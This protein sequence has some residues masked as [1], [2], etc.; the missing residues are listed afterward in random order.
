MSDGVVL[1]QTISLNG[2]SW[3]LAADPRNVGKKDGWFIAA[4]PEA[5]NAP[6]PG[7]IQQVLPGYSGYAWYWKS[8]A[9]QKNP[10]KAGTYLLRFWDLDYIGEV[11]VNGK[12]V[13]SHE[14]AQQRFDL[15]I[16]KAVK[17]GV[18]NLIAIK[19]LSPFGAPIDGIE[20]SQTPH[21]ALRDFNLGGLIDDVELLVRPS[22]YQDDLFVRPNWQTGQVEVE[23][24]TI[25]TTHGPLP[26]TFR[27]EISP[28]A[29]GEPIAQTSAKLYLTSGKNSAEARLRVPNHILWDLKKPYLYR[30]TCRLSIDG[31]TSVDQ[32]AT[33][34]GFRDFRFVDGFF[35]LNGKRIFWSSAHTGADTPITISVPVDSSMV[36]KDL[37]NLKLCGFTGIRFISMLGKRAQLDMADELGLLVYEESY[38]SWMLSDSP[39]LAERFDRSLTG[40]V[41]RDRNHP[42]VAM[43]GLLNETGPGPVCDHARNSLPLMRMLDPTRPVMFSSGRFDSETFLN[44][45]VVW[46]P[47]TGF[48]P[49]IAFNPKTYSISGV[50]LFRSHEAS[51]IPGVNGEFSCVRFVAPEDGEYTVTAKFRG[52]GT[53]TISDVYVLGAG[54]TIFSS[55]INRKGLGDLARFEGTVKLAKGETVDFAVGGNTPAGG[56]WYEKWGNNTSLDLE[57]S[58]VGRRFHLSAKSLVKQN[59]YGEWQFGWMT[60]GSTPDPAQFKLYGLPRSESNATNGSFSNPG[61]LVWENLLGDQ[62]YYPRV[63]HRELEIARLRT[64]AIDDKP[65]FL[66]EYGIGGGVDMARFIANCEMLGHGSDD[67]LAGLKAQYETFKN[68]FVRLKL[69]DE[70]ASPQDFLQKAVE[71]EGAMKALGLNALRSNPNLV[72]YGMTGLNDPLE[73]GEGFITAFRELK[74]GT[75][76]AIYEGLAPVK[77]C[78]FAE[79]VQVYSG[80]EVRL[81]AVLSNFDTLPPGSYSLR[82]QAVDP[83]GKKVL[84]ERVTMTVTP[85][86]ASFVTP[87]FDR[88]VRVD[89]PTGKYRF[90]VQFESGAAATGGEA[91][92]YVANRAEMPADKSDVVLWGSDPFLENGLS[93]SGIKYHPYTPDSSSNEVILVSAAAPSPNDDKVWQDL[94][95]RIKAGSTAVFLCP[96]V[97]AKGDQQLGWLPLDKKGYLSFVSEFTFPQVYPKDEWCKRHPIFE[98]LPTGLMDHTFY[99]EMIPDFQFAGLPTPDEAVAGAFRTSMPGAYLCNSFVS[100]YKLGKG[101][102]VL[103]ALR[104]RQELGNDPVAER[105]LRNMLRYAGS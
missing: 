51:A 95:D 85:K 16:T 43:W 48:A 40:M 24:V 47:D 92:F 80:S 27:V 100:V 90:I 104:I 30:V 96:E 25:N 76:D 49:A 88:F 31:S 68:D 14:G 62:H 37:L 53:F 4:R 98:G 66:S 17:P 1:N 73:C 63:P 70:F 33:R 64:I 44:G 6:V 5:K 83:N 11:W 103:N 93:K 55:S 34:F 41:L 78:A 71:R 29:G 79:P 82:V 54:K 32:V 99:R 10:H 77:L 12:P 59:P 36:R 57:V 56:A 15:D 89:G 105:L 61:S 7:T 69:E 38:A 72:G 3:Q 94:V 21:G 22:V 28:A 86:S 58:G 2:N 84:N 26:A 23:V 75:T 20:R 52:T 101:R 13:G 42:S 50:T 46:K 87:I 45:L 91:V 39:Q 97:F 67:R 81:E 8:L 65:L 102:I 35:R 74:K 19:V 9:I 18:T 60:A